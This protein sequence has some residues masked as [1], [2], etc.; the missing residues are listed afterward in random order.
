MQGNLSGW[1]LPLTNVVFA[2]CKLDPALW[3]IAS[4]IR[5]KSKAKNQLYSLIFF[6]LFT[7]NNIRF[8]HG[9]E[10]FNICCGPRGPRQNVT[11]KTFGWL[12]LLHTLNLFLVHLYDY[13]QQSFHYFC[14][15]SRSNIEMTLLKKKHGL[16]KSW[17]LKST[18]KSVG[19]CVILF[20]KLMN[21]ESKIISTVSA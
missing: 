7:Q 2:L 8:N 20:D 5:R 11:L 19:F 3:K 9:F 1:C 17:V 18:G 12:L 21:I 4:G 6:F 16:S 14:H 15:L 10:V 13:F